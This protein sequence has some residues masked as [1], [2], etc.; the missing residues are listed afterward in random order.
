MDGLRIE[1]FSEEVE[2]ELSNFD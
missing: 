1:I 2:Y